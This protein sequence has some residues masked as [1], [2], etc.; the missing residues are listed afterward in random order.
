M[1][2]QRILI[3][4]LYSEENEFERCRRSVEEQDYCHWEHKIFSGLSNKAAHRALYSEIM[5]RSSE[6]DLFLKLDADM[7]LCHD[8]IFRDIISYFARYRDLDHAIFAVRDFMTQ[9]PIMGLHVFSK[10]AVWTTF[11]HRIFVDSNPQ[12]PGKRMHVWDDPAPIALH[13][14]DP[15]PE[16]AFF[17]GV[18][19]ALKALQ[20]SRNSDFRPMQALKQWKTLDKVWKHYLRTLDR[21][22]A[23]ALYGAELVRRGDIIVNDS[24][25]KRG[26][27]SQ[28]CERV[29][30]LSE[31]EINAGLRFWS[32]PKLWRVTW[33]T[34]RIAPQAMKFA[35]TRLLGLSRA[36]NDREV[37]PG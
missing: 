22:L 28:Q 30:P 7:V 8:R 34:C 16:Q 23:L 9:R 12:I 36:G 27:V 10:R 19:H 1:N 6:F 11:E 26:I 17:F 18:H 21:R 4:T 29:L 14:P 13:S 5:K 33:W 24:E 25:Y 32:R 37:H 15:S 20:Q 31:E 35:V 2:E 3:L